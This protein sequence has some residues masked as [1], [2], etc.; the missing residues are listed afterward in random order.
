MSDLGTSPVR[1]VRYDT[2][3]R[4]TQFRY[5]AGQPDEAETARFV[6]EW[7]AA[8]GA[9]A[10]DGVLYRELCRQVPEWSRMA[11][12]EMDNPI[13]AAF[14][15]YLVAEAEVDLSKVAGMAAEVCDSYQVIED[16]HTVA[17]RFVKGEEVKPTGALMFNLFEI[18]GPAGME[19]GFLMDWPP[20]GEF[21]INED[22]TVSTMLARSRRRFVR[23]VHLHRDQP[24]Q[25][26]CTRS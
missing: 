3:I 25:A 12:K 5:G 16:L 7:K 15:E 20:R 2:V 8:C 10:E 13:E 6:R 17:F 23:P 4:L 19:Q 26:R 9:R 18:D 21:K 24:A 14:V 11:A 22:A 1:V